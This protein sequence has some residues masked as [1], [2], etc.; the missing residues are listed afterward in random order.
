L[1]LD[2]KID[3]LITFLP[4]LNL[5]ETLHAFRFAGN[6]AAHELEAL[7]RD[8]ART[9]IEVMEALLNFLYDLDYKASQ[10]RHA[11]K[12]AAFKSTM[13]DSVE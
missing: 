13:P 12:R 2:R 3:G 8:D 1:W 9:A 5:I 10:M 11:S 4:S 6:D 7:T